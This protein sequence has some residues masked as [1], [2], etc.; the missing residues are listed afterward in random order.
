MLH[1]SELECFINNV[2]IVF[3]SSC[4]LGKL[5]SC[6]NQIPLKPDE[7]DVSVVKLSHV[8]TN[9]TESAVFKQCRL[10]LIVKDPFFTD[11][12]VASP[13]IGLLC[14]SD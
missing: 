6:R 4:L 11:Y 1:F 5:C 7:G 9:E 8:H 10:S 3:L 14:F 2:A 13:H 12:F